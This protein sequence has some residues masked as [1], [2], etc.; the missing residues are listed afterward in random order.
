MLQPGQSENDLIAELKIWLRLHPSAEFAKTE[1]AQGDHNCF[2]FL[3]P[4]QF[5]AQVELLSELG[6]GKPVLK[7]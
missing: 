4:P 3:S 5:G 7:A 1:E 6:A 2:L